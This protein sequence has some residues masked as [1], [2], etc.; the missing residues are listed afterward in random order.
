V[1]NSGSYV[2]FLDFTT[3]HT[4]GSLVG[5]TGG[6]IESNPLFFGPTG[7]V[8]YNITGGSITA[9][10]PDQGSSLTLLSI[11]LLCGLGFDLARRRVMQV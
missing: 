2:F 3:G 4:P 8:V 10:V 9:P 11:V 1:G 5:F 6:T 7:I